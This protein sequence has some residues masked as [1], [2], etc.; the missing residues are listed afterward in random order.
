MY[1]T[2]SP[3]SGA[4]DGSAGDAPEVLGQDGGGQSALTVSFEESPQDCY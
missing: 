2:H 1:P 3:G 4:N